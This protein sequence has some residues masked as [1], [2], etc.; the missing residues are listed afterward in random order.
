MLPIDIIDFTLD[1]V[2]R[3]LTKAT[4]Q[5]S[6]QIT[7]LYRAEAGNETAN[8]LWAEGVDLAFHRSLMFNTRT[9][10]QN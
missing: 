3:R 4:L 6:D 2:T 10:S 5:P 8:D 1:G 9:V 7:T